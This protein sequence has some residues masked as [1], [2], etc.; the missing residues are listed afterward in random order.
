MSSSP[1]N[2]R[3]EAEAHVRTL[4]ALLETQPPA[5][6]RDRLIAECSSLARA[7]AAFHMEGIRFRMY[8]VDRTLAKA[9]APVP[10][11]AAG[12]FAE[13]RRHLEA[14]GFQTRSH[15]APGQ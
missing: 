8:N 12:L 11:G 7:I 10:E 4:I 15:K 2:H 5:P 1:T 6:E 14:A 13:A 3:Q 9:A